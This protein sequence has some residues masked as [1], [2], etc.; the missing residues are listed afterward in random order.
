MLTDDQVAE[1][2]AML[3]DFTD[4]QRAY[5]QGWVTCSLELTR[6]SEFAQSSMA[7]IARCF[8]TVEGDRHG[9]A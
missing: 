2:E 5:I 6:G 3:K 8:S 9:S 7:E 4:V 1:V